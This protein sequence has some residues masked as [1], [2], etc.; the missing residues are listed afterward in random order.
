MKKVLLIIAAVLSSIIGFGQAVSIGDIL[1]TDGSIIKPSEY[2]SS[3]K[4]AW[5]IVFYVDR[6][7]AHGWAVALNNQ[8]SS[9]QWSSNSNYGYDIPNLP[10]FEN[11]RTAMHDLDGKRNT[12]TIRNEGFGYD[13]PAAWAVDFDEGWYLPS[14]G[15]LRYLYSYIPEIN[16]SLRIAGGANIPYHDN[17]YYWSSTE[18]TG[19]HAYDM[20]SG[21]SLGDYVKDNHVNY[22][23]NGIAVRQIRDFDIPSP[24]H[25]V[26]HVGDLITNEDGS[27][28]ILFY[29]NPDQ[30]DG[31]MVALTDAATSV[32]WGNGT[33]VLG[34]TNQVY[35]SPYGK[36]LDETDGFANT[37]YIR[38]AQNG[39]TTAANVVDYEHGW[40][41]PTAGQ[42]SKLFGSLP[43]IEDKLMAYG[44]TLSYG[45]YWSSSEANADQA[46][47]LTCYPE[48]NVR[49]GG[50]VMRNKTSFL[51]VRAV[52]N[53]VLEMNMP[54][55]GN[56]SI[57]EPICDHTSLIL[58]EPAS[59]FATSQGW[60]ICPT[61]DF[62][63]PQPYNG[64]SIDLSYN[65]WYLRYFASNPLGT[66]YSNTIQISV[67]PTVET[68]F[69]VA[70][71]T[72][73]LWNG[74]AYSEPGVYEQH[75]ST[76]H[77]CDSLV[78]LHLSFD[79][80]NQREVFLTGCDQ[81]T[82][83]DV[84]YTQS[85]HFQQI[86]PGDTGCDTI[87][88]LFLNLGHSPY[89]SSIHGESLIYYKECG[90]F[91]YSIDPVEGCFGYEWSLDGPWSITS[92]SDSPECTVSIYTSGIGTLKVRVYTEC[93]FTERF[94][95]INHDV[96]PWVEVWPNP[97]KGD[98]SIG[99]YGMRGKAVI[100]VFDYIGQLI[101]RISAD[102]YMEGT[103]IPYS[104]KGKAA[105]VYL[106]T[107]TN[108]PNVI[109]KKVVK[110]SSALYGVPL[111]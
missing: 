61:P 105:G 59:Q 49:A 25:P 86:V 91:V 76:I 100:E 15:Q 44:N 23:P 111:W 13:F 11:A 20:N 34:L 1:C 8:S 32:S 102:T 40:Y 89:I 3:G 69:Y 71:C 41:L 84:T 58:Q 108:G 5:G 30:T 21:G 17:Y 97:N 66:A 4:T 94:L 31:W 62:S 33:D 82:Y 81:I 106:L 101:D 63:N 99:L 53:I 77:G 52:R 57:L 39:M 24:S 6:N 10:N 78:T 110:T 38:A 54:T 90:D 42:L 43:F 65:G 28:G 96:R 48:A 19:Y 47:G 93:G 50:F 98:F 55:V 46:F 83:N 16:A 60:Q 75:L 35:N 67:L 29:V 22:P 73:Y 79:S 9:I 74:I 103:E 80:I 72:E 27:R 2:A 26:Y 56:I 64:E 87:I 88:H 36:L 109:T 85:G 95:T 12:E 37:G 70:S 7:D 104:L 107:I 51:H 14:A 45:Y 18:F 68:S 92:S